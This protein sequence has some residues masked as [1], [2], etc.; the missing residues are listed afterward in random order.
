MGSSRSFE[1]TLAGSWNSDWT[2]GVVQDERIPSAVQ[3]MIA[4]IARVISQLAFPSTG[5]LYS[6]PGYRYSAL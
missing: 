4:T 3:P 1:D 2:G 5:G 6:T